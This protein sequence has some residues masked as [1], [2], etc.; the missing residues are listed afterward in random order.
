MAATNPSPQIQFES[1]LR[2]R[3]TCPPE[4]LPYVDS[5]L[6]GICWDNDTMIQCKSKSGHFD[7]M[8]RFFDLEKQN[9]A[10]IQK[11]RTIL[12]QIQL[13]KSLDAMESGVQAIKDECRG[14]NFTHLE[15]LQTQL[16]RLSM[17]E[18]YLAKIRDKM[19]EDACGD[20]DQEEFQYVPGERTRKRKWRSEEEEELVKLRSNG[21]RIKDIAKT[22]GRSK[23][24]ILE[25]IR[26]KQDVI[27]IPGVRVPPPAPIPVPVPASA[28]VSVSAPLPEPHIPK[29]M[30]KWTD[31]QKKMFRDMYARGCMD[32]EIADALG[33]TLASISNR[34]QEL[35]L[36]KNIGPTSE[37]AGRKPGCKDWTKEQERKLQELFDAGYTYE[38]I[39]KRIGRGSANSIK[40]K[41]YR[42]G[43]RRQGESI[44]VTAD[45]LAVASDSDS[46]SNYNPPPRKRRKAIGGNRNT[47]WTDA[48]KQKL[49]ELFDLGKTN[50]EIALELGR[51]R[52]GVV[53]E[54][55]RQG[56][57]RKDKQG[58]DDA[59]EDLFGAETESESG[60]DTDYESDSEEDAEAAAEEMVVENIPNGHAEDHVS[61]V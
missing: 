40:Q 42:L 28:P 53:Q 7:K 20:S 60:S 55:V 41:C 54:C 33:R 15:N 51:S 11:I 17:M 25:K 49:R 22:L 35:R 10:S 21:L 8:M 36:A 45:S 34:R 5:I 50:A 24:S 14:S 19:T 46:D 30:R 27:E 39:A 12:D 32:E 57:R 13:E 37:T 2:L 48:Q 26:E 9:L 38:E 6:A 29:P 16:V 59:I 58:V 23:A 18:S 61:I 1:A 31:A 52:G 3:A 43:L 4:A 47:I 56:L 44:D